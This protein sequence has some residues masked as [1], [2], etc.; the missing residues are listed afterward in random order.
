MSRRR[1]GVAVAVLAV[2][3]VV[4]TFVTFV[5]FVTRLPADGLPGESVSAKRVPDGRP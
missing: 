3:A 4:V 5:T 2:L 1:H